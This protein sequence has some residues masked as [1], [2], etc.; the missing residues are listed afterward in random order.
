M[1]DYLMKFPMLSKELCLNLLMKFSD[2]FGSKEY[3]SVEKAMEAEALGIYLL[4]S[5]TLVDSYTKYFPV[6]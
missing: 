3:H 6:A 4:P 1:Y 5:Q 2:M